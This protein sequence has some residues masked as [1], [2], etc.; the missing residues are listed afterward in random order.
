[1]ITE[2][3]MCK[4]KYRRKNGNTLLLVPSIHDLYFSLFYGVTL[5][6]K[7]TKQRFGSLY[8]SCWHDTIPMRVWYLRCTWDVGF[9]MDL[10]VLTK[11]H[12][13]RNQYRFDIELVRFSMGH[14]ILKQ[15]LVDQVNW[16]IPTHEPICSKMNHSLGSVQGWF[17]VVQSYQF[18]AGLIW[19][20]LN[21]LVQYGSVILSLKH[22]GWYRP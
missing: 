7:S 2:E 13:I 16:K 4:M 11:V 6:W 3:R 8:S 17:W 19:F 15:W 5:T 18:Q 14:T 12:C 1:M 22:L 9:L 10:D 20:A 21:C